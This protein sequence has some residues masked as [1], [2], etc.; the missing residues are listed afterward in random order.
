L[1]KKPGDANNPDIITA[2][3]KELDEA[4]FVYRTRT[5]D[6]IDANGRV[7]KRK[8]IQIIFFHREVIRLTWRFIA[9]KLL[10]VDS[11]FN[12][13]KL[14]LPL[15]IGVGITNSGETFLYASS[16]CP[17]KTAESFD[18]FFQILREEM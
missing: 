14:R 4:G 6:E 5:E 2:L 1:R 11:T 17:G 18:F 15:L 3:L 9:R 13:N 8:L 10:V 16:Y 7:V 12:T